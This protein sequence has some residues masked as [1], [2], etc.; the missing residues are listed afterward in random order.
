MGS[1]LLLQHFAVLLEHGQIARAQL[2]RACA[3]VSDHAHAAVVG[4]RVIIGVHFRAVE[5]GR[6][7]GEHSIGHGHGAISA[8]A[9]APDV[10][11]ALVEG[12]RSG[13]QVRG[14][15][16]NLIARPRL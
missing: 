8:S 15:R 13:P 5:D 6:F 10:E 4:R 7:G 3:R 12:A 1:L 11:P 16:T 2:H 9:G 14:R